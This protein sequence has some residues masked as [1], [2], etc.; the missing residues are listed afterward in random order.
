MFEDM[1]SEQLKLRPSSAIGRQ[2]QGH[3]DDFASH[4]PERARQEGRIYPQC[5]ASQ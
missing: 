3:S 4:V 2:A 1:L 5:R